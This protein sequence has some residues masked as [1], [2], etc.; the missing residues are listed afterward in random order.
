MRKIRMIS[1]ILAFLLV[2]SIPVGATVP[3]RSYNY[4]RWEDVV[5]S[6]VPYLPE[7]S[8]SGYDLGVGPLKQPGDFCVADN[9]DIYLADTG[10]NR[11]LVFDKDLSLIE[12]I[13]TFLHEGDQDG[14]NLPSGVFV[15]GKGDLYIADSENRRIVA[16]TKNRELKLIIKNP[17][18]ETF[19]EGFDFVPI[20]VGVDYADRIYVIARGVFEGIMSFDETG[21]FYGYVGTINVA[22]SPIDIV[23]RTLSTKAQREKQLLYIPTE[24]TGLDLDKEGFVY[25]TNIDNASNETIKRLNPSGKDVLKRPAGRLVKGDLMYSLFGQYGGPSRFVDM[26]IRDKGIYSAVDAQRGRVFTYDHE[27]NLLYIFGGIGSQ[28]GT[29]KKPV[30]I[31][32]A[33]EHLLILDQERGEI[34]K[35]A[36]SEYGTF[37]NIAVG[38]RYDGDEEEAVHYWREVLKRNANFELAYVG[39]GKSLLAKGDNKGAMTYLKLGMDQKYYSVAYKR[40]RNEVLKANLGYILTGVIMSVVGLPLVAKLR[41]GRRRRKPQH[42]RSI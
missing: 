31:E 27:G 15:T 33:G 29:F 25:T 40:Y 5:P 16:L 34:I 11:I 22:I 1:M 30:A 12:E 3:Y 19:E 37:I 23:W 4:D 28:V 13:T 36:P 20:K 6:P 17:E 24:F 26:V 9:G 18:S 7:A 14:F 10:N 32:N 35:F 38:L 2:L 39:I 8:F 42:A 41:K 21:K